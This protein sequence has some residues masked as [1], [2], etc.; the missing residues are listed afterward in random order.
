MKLPPNQKYNSNLLG[1]GD[2]QSS[3]LHQT[4]GDRHIWQIIWLLAKGLRTE[5]S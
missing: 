5:E 4:I 1:S 2:K 3:R